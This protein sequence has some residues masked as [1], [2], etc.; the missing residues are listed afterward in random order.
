MPERP[1]PGHVTR[2]AVFSVFRAV[3][4]R[5]PDYPNPDRLVWLTLSGGGLSASQE[6]ISSLG[7]LT[8]SCVHQPS[9][10]TGARP[11]ALSEGLDI[12]RRRVMR[13]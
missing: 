6:R 12:V 2:N 13:R 9:E 8:E 5:P 3:M 1:D 7:F 4:L 11:S 10:Q